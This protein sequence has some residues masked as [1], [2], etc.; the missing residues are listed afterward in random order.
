MTRG[1]HLWHR[2]SNYD[3]A[4]DEFTFRKLIQ[5]NFASLSLEG[6]STHR[7]LVERIAEGSSVSRSNYCRTSLPKLYFDEEEQFSVAPETTSTKLPRTTRTCSGGSL[8]TA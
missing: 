1:Q 6:P 5:D 7:K 2:F 4:V 8:T 3:N